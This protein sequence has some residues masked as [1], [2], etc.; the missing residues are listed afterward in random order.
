M[1]QAGVVASLFKMGDQ[2]VCSKY[3]EIR[4]FRKVYPTV[5]ERAVW[6]FG[7]MGNNAVFSLG[8]GTLDQLYTPASVLER[9]G[10][11]LSVSTCVL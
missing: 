9:H 4:H 10:N 8:S 11:L 1:S 5:L 2:G 3:R 6:L 7:C